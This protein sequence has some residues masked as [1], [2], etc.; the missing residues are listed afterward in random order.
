MVM[1]H[2]PLAAVEAAALFARDPDYLLQ[3]ARATR[4][5]VA[6]R[7]VLTLEACA[8]KK[9]AMTIMELVQATGLAKTT[10]HRMCWKLVE[11]GLL[12]H[13]ADGFSVGSKMF[14]LAAANPRISQL[15]I[16]AIPHLVELQ[17]RTGAMSNIAI[18]SNGRALVIDGLFTTGSVQTLR[19][20][21]HALP[22]HCTA[23]GKAI[24]AQF[25][26]EERDRLLF[27]KGPLAR[28][29]RNTLVQPGLL[30]QHIQRVAE[31]GI[32]VADR[33]FLP[34]IK[35]VAA[36]FRLRDGGAAAIGVLEAWNSPT[37]HNAPL[38]VAAAAAALH[39]ELSQ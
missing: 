6:Q 38:A 22:L 23:L 28:A 13:S 39:R 21:G 2:D 36:G 37:L 19:L 11:L 15:R 5:P 29:T 32:A 10:V 7:I 24:A 20:I 27:S 12:E 1:Q 4:E 25:E 16:A 26:P 3:D 33:D 9:G 31:T 8:S 35:A 17:R 14:A 18:L 34:D 30:R